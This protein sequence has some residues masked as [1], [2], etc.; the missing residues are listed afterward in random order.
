MNYYQSS[1]LFIAGCSCLAGIIFFYVAVNLSPKNW[2]YLYFALMSLSLA[3]FAAVD[4]QM[5]ATSTVERYLVWFKIGN[6]FILVFGVFLLHFVSSYTRVRPTLF[7]AIMTLGFAIY[8]PMT[9]LSPSALLYEQIS[10][11]HILE[12]PWGETL[13]T[14]IGTTTLWAFV[15]I[16]G[17]CAIYL[18]ALLAAYIQFKRGERRDAML[19]SPV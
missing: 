10:A 11:L 17:L 8:I 5:F 14:P 7:L 16:G 4:A 13:A 2:T 18:Y 9:L 6:V 12:L 1:L 19:Q 3:G 15:F